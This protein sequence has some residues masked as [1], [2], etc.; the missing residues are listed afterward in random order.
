L[1]AKKKNSSVQ[2]VMEAVEM[3]KLTDYTCNPNPEYLLEYNRLIAQQESF[4]KEV[5]NPETNPA[6]HSATT[7]KSL[8]LL[9]L[10]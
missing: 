10:K 6:K 5:L 4:V 8:P 2:H 7:L 3:E 9:L 1:I